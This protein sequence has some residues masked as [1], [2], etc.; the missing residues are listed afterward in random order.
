MSTMTAGANSHRLASLA[1]SQIT[2]MIVT[3]R[4]AVDWK[5][6]ALSPEATLDQIAATADQSNAGSRVDGP[7]KVYR[8]VHLPDQLIAE[9][10]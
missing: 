7:A 9:K 4:V 2:A 5:S 6:P 10:V 8:G 3:G 1:N